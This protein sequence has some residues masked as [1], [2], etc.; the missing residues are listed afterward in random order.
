MDRVFSRVNPFFQIVIVI[1]LPLLVVT[2]LGW[3]NLQYARQ[4]PGGH[5]F[6]VYYT[7]ARA[8]L[9]QGQSPYEDAVAEDIQAEFAALSS[10]EAEQKSRFVHPLYSL[11]FFT[12]L[13][14]ISDFTL[15]RAA[16]MTVLEIVVLLTAYI[17]LRLADWKPAWGVKVLFYLFSIVW[18]Y[19]VRALITG[20]VVILICFLISLMML[21]IKKGWDRW[22]GVLLAVSTITPRLVIFVVMLVWIWAFSTDRGSILKWFGG[23]LIVLVGGS[24]AL[25]PDWVLQNLWSFLKFL[26]NNPTL[27]VGGVLGTWLPGIEQQIKWIIPAI[28]TVI[29][30]VEWR[31]VRKKTIY[32]LVWTVALT[33]TASQWIGI[34]THP[35][36]FFI[37][38][39]ALVFSL[40]MWQKRW[41]RYGDLVVILILGVLSVG[42]WLLIRKSPQKSTQVLQAPGMIFP[43]PAFLLLALYWVRF[44]VV[45]PTRRIFE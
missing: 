6:L 3:A 19:T 8:L 24:S 16:W 26:E 21:S 18:A 7:G 33:L 1:I 20:N 11:I 14:V 41:E 40:A 35:D 12:P 42:G 2:G 17:N 22:A 10:P 23:T 29:L 5:D 9:I 27:T 43:L 31:S 37:L 32:H 38:Y 36:H 39:P 30:L 34:P 4:N 44:W 25:L 45:H 28:M 13:S 15:A